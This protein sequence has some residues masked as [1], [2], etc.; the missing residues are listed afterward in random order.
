MISANLAKDLQVGR[1][2]DARQALLRRLF[3]ESY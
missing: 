3:S 1:E 2:Y